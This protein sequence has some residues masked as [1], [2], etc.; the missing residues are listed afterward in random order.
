MV[1]H[2]EVKRCSRQL[3]AVCD[4]TETLCEKIDKLDTTLDKRLDDIRNAST[5]IIPPETILHLTEIHNNFCRMFSDTIEKQGT[6]LVG[7]LDNRYQKI[8]RR[9][10]EH[11]R[12]I[13]KQT[14]RITVPDNLLLCDHV[15]ASFHVLW[16]RV[17]GELRIFPY[18]AVTKPF[19]DI[20]CF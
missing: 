13:R 14:E 17:L 1:Y 8:E 16:N 19:V 7:Q 3:V 20:P 4:A 15:C 11:E 12:V 18:K 5:V 9:I 10:A 2:L 6:E